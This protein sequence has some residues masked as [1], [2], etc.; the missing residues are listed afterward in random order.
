[1]TNAKQAL[2]NTQN[3]APAK[4]QNNTVRGLLMAMKGEIQNAL[5]SYLPVE[6]F[7]RT[8]L[9]AINSNPKLANCT[10]ESLL[11]AIM[12]SAQLGLEFNTPLGEAFLI[13]YLN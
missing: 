1:M 4:K 9:T 2:K 13:P 12:N 3:K 6:K 10:Q 7:I 8:A 11:A 5:P